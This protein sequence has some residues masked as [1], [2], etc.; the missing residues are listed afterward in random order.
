MFRKYKRCRRLD[1]AGH[2]HYLTFSCYNQL[3]LLRSPSVCRILANAVD[4][5][6]QS[7][8][9]DIWGWV[10]M[11]EHVHLLI[12]PSHEAGPISSI[13]SA[14]KR[15][16][17]VEAI[18]RIKRSAHPLLERMT[19]RTSS[20]IRHRFWQPG[21]GYD[22]NISDVETAWLTVD[23][24]HANPVRRGLVEA[25]DASDWSSSRDWTRGEAAYLKVDRTIPARME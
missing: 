4:D 22:R 17:A 15:P 20:G 6:R 18:G 19:V 9:F 12:L 10:F 1:V 23:Y 13:L 8:R 21:G 25:A 14:I 16:T 24:I 5:A 11:P 7:H 2:A 3:P